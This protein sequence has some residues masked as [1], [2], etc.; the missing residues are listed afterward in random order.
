MGYLIKKISIFTH[1]FE[2]K[3]EK[4]NRSPKFH[5]KIFLAWGGPFLLAFQG[6]KILEKH[7]RAPVHTPKKKIGRVIWN[8]PM[9]WALFW[10]QTFVKIPSWGRFSRLAE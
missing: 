10:A 1:F 6:K 4:N 5:L 8:S 9:A 7:K 3:V 2:E